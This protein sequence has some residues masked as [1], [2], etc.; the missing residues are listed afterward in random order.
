MNLKITLTNKRVYIYL[1]ILVIVI[2]VLWGTF[3]PF[4]IYKLPRSI[5]VPDGWSS[6]KTVSPNEAS[7]DNIF[8][9]KNKGYFTYNDRTINQRMCRQY[10]GIEWTE[11]KSLFI[12]ADLSIESVAWYT[13]ENKLLILFGRYLA[14]YNT[15][16]T[17]F[18]DFYVGLESIT[19]TDASQTLYTNITVEGNRQEYLYTEGIQWD[20]IKTSGLREL[21]TSQKGYRVI[22]ILDS[23]NKLHIIWYDEINNNPNKLYHCYWN[24]AQ[25]SA[26]TE[27]PSDNTELSETDRDSFFALVDEKEVVRLI[28]V[29]RNKANLY[30]TSYRNNQWAQP[31]KIAELEKTK[32]EL[33]HITFRNFV[34]ALTDKKGNLLIAV[35]MYSKMSARISYMEFNGLKCTKPVH[36]KINRAMFRPPARMVLINDTPYLFWDELD[37][38]LFGDYKSHIYYTSKA[39]ATK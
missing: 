9:N 6:V 31:V 17:S 28:W 16:N 10:D 38:S 30:H 35:S 5:K 3:L 29:S 12:P 22:S 7:L 26:L 11:P 37:P 8:I 1:V 14:T 23:K 39:N 24:G 36:V 25:W 2:A 20:I 18:D 32:A 33:G 13:K 21:L 27:I 4:S 19:K 34:D 15:S